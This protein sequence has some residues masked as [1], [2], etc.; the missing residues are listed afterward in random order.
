MKEWPA[1]IFRHLTSILVVVA[2]MWTIA[3]PHVEDFI[4]KTVNER[5]TRLE[6]QMTKVEGLLHRIITQTDKIE[7][8]IMPDDKL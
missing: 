5:I 8:R 6:Q 3:K 1:I 4:R 2:I 7:D